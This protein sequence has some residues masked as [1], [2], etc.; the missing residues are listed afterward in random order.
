MNDLRN[1]D[2]VVGPDTTPAAGNINSLENIVI[3]S[4]QHL[5]P[6]KIYIPP[7]VYNEDKGVDGYDTYVQIVPLLGAMEIEGKQI[8]EEEEAKPPVAVPV[9]MNVE[10]ST[11]IV[12][13]VVS[14][15][16]AAGPAPLAKQSIAW[17]KEDLKLRF[18]PTQG[19][20]KLLIDILKYAMNRK[21]VW[22]STL[23]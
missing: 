8:F 23:E 11:R 12:L 17:F 21:L 20:N 6:G 9:Q 16:G 22:Y 10:S 2:R 14:V 1:S 15:A 19:N 5:S 7:G 13:N 4:S 18:Q 3:S